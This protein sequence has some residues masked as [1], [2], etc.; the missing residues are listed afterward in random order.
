MYNQ[1][2]SNMRYFR[3]NI[4]G[5]SDHMWWT[6]SCASTDTCYVTWTPVIPQNDTYEV[7]AYI[8]SVN[9]NAS[10]RYEIHHSG[11]TA[12][13]NI[14]QSNFSDEWVSIGSYYFTTNGGYV[15]LGDATGTPGQR[16]AFDAMKWSANSIG[17]AEKPD[18]SQPRLCRL[19]SNIV[20]NSLMINITDHAHGQITVS[21]YD[22]TGKCIYQND[23]RIQDN[24]NVVIDVSNLTNSIYF[25]IVANQDFKYSEKFIVI[26][27]N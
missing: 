15:Y 7:F 8:P 23:H 14:D 12:I 11:G 21:I 6:Y 22:I 1:S 19:L 9:A 16:I 17:T 3:D 25:M 20:K 2:P 4:I 13:I 24:R 10:A 26:R 27:N 5:Y 18:H